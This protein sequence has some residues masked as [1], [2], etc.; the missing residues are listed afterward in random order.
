MKKSIITLLILVLS[1]SSFSQSNCNCEQAL[2]QLIERVESD[3]PGF[4]EKT[5]YKLIYSNFKEGLRAKSQSIEES[6]CLELLRT[7][8]KFFKDGHINLKRTNVEEVGQAEEMVS[9]AHGKVEIS[10]EDFY[11]HISNSSD[12]LEGVWTSGSYKVGLLKSDNEYQ[13]FIIEAGNKSWKANEIKFRL[14]GDGKANYYMSDHSLQE[15]N[16]EVFDGSILS[17]NDLSSVFLKELPK[18]TLTENEIQMKL[19]E[20]D[21]FYFR[22]LSEKTV[23]LR[24]SSFDQSY[25]E[26]IEKLIDDNIKLIE[27]CENLIIDV[28]DNHG[29]TDNAYEKLLPYICTNNLRSVGKEFLATQTIIDGYQKWLD[30][31]PDEEK[32]MKDRKLVN[33]SIKLFKENLG[34]F[35]NIDTTNTYITEVEIAEHSPEQ[36]VILAN[37]MSASSGENFVFRMKQ[38]KKVKILGTPTYGALDYAS[39][40]YFKFGCDNYQLLLPS[41]RASRLPDYPIDNIGVQ[42]DVYL[43]Q[44]VEDWIQY[45]LDYVEN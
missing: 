5:T 4:A 23:L 20:L 15:D 33:H 13:G 45:A 30:I 21:G 26:R 2:N 31:T 36:V 40:Y 32:Y 8:L 38:S 7:Y 25:V 37:K 43:D 44:Y 9:K 12:K 6:D 42:P 35:V 22:K 11:K 41:W 14:M 29:G 10:I 39:A 34:G 18:P 16:F 19:N 3:Y 27:N 28:R 17:F 1:I 24:M